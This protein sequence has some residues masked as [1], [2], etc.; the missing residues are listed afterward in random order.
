MQAVMWFKEL[1]RTDTGRAGGKGANLGELWSGGFPVPDGFVVTAD[2]YLAA[3]DFG[4][5]RA[6]LK[7]ATGAVD[8]DDA[9][10]LAGL[11]QKLQAL[12][13]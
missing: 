2:A 8:P 6:E 11:S 1:R 12:V 10:A 7:S 5:I 13:R 4:G 3:M 9:P